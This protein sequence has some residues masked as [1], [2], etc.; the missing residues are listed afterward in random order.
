M[1]VAASALVLGSLV[2]ADWT[3]SR[4]WSDSVPHQIEL[5]IEH[6]DRLHYVGHLALGRLFDLGPGMEHLAIEQYWRAEAHATTERQLAL[7]TS[8]RPQTLET[9]VSDVGGITAS[10]FR[11]AQR[12]TIW[13]LDR[14]A[15]RSG[16][17]PPWGT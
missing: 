16:W 13:L 10:G 11:W 15:A 2:F 7:V 4:H 9:Q 3:E 8:A 14:T 5:A 1:P 17:G 6:G 12:G